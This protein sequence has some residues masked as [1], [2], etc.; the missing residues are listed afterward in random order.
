MGASGY[1]LKKAVIAELKAAL[2]RV[3][4]GEIYLSREI[5]TRLRNNFPL[6]RDRPRPQPGRA[7][8]RRVSARFSSLLPRAK[9]PRKSPSS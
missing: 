9:P 8:D 5:S 7:V 4:G 3:A 6:Q 2:Q 1:L